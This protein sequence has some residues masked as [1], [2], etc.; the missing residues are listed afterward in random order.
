MFCSSVNKF[1]SDF[2]EP[3]EMRLE[4]GKGGGVF[5]IKRQTVPQI[6]LLP[7]LETDALPESLGNLVKQH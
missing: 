5:H 4:G 2:I 7:K 6:N 3:V 1:H